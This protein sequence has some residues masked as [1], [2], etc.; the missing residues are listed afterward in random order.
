VQRLE[1]GACKA[2]RSQLQIDATVHLLPRSGLVLTNS[3][4]DECLR[5]DGIM[6]ERPFGQS[7]KRRVGPSG[8]RV[9]FGLWGKRRFG[10]G[11]VELGVSRSVDPDDGQQGRH[12]VEEVTIG[13]ALEGVDKALPCRGARDT[14]R[15]VRMGAVGVMAGPVHSIEG[16]SIWSKRCRIGDSNGGQLRSVACGG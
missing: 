6:V 7:S 10:R 1:F 11:V 14:R 4:L 2:S 3:R 15:W 8:R 16:Q 5:D 9:Q 12:W 13:G